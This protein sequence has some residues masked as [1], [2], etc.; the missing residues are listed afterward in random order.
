MPEFLHV[1]THRDIR[2]GRKAAK[3]V[4]ENDIQK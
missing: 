3:L 1:N 4:V 2:K